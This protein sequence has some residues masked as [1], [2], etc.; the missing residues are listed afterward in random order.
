MRRH[1][2]PAICFVN[3]CDRAGA[4]FLGASDVKFVGSNAPPSAT[5]NVLSANQMECFVP[6]DAVNGAI[7]VFAP[8]GP[9]TSTNTFAVQHTGPLSIAVAP[10]NRYV[11][12]W[13]STL[14]NYRLEATTNLA[15]PIVWTNTAYPTL[16]NG[17]QFYVSNAVTDSPKFFRIINP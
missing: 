9:I 4:N 7:T 3:K 16:S 6:L 1:H 5:F 8:A 12:R 13:S 11:I 17:G 10:T 14:T 2:V 15:A